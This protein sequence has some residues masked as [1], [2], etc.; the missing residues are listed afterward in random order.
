MYRVLLPNGELA[1][2][3]KIDFLVEVTYG[4]DKKYI[5]PGR[6]EDGISYALT[7]CDCVYIHLESTKGLLLKGVYSSYI[8]DI[9]ETLLKEG[10]YDFTRVL[11]KHKELVWL[12]EEEYLR[13]IGV[14]K[15]E[16][17][18]EDCEDYIEED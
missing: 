11:F 12:S 4:D 1:L 8:K 3:T 15:D 17:R 10:Y 7:D 5:Q 14:I 18:E 13:Y 6:L 16:A 2:S 9:S